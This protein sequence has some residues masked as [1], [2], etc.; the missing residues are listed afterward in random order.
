MKFALKVIAMLV[1]TL[2]FAVSLSVLVMDIYQMA[3]HEQTIPI[4][5][6]ILFTVVSG[7]LLLFSA[8]KVTEER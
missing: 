5:P 4:V 7:I 6:V 1:T 3:H 8:N 2:C